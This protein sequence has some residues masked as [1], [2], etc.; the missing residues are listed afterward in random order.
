[1]H[2]ELGNKVMT[3]LENHAELK[4]LIQSA[5]FNEIDADMQL[6][7]LKLHEEVDA[8]MNSLNIQVDALDVKIAEMLCS[9]NL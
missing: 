8:T 6:A 7:L 1:M 9:L 2:T 5:Q 3:L 4:S